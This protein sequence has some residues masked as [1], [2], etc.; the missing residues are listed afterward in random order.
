MTDTTTLKARYSE[1]HSTLQGRR[2][3]VLEEAH[4]LS[5]F[6]EAVAIERGTPARVLKIGQDD[7]TVGSHVALP[8]SAQPVASSPSTER[9]NRNPNH[10]PLKESHMPS[11]SIVTPSILA[12]RAPNAPTQLSPAGV[13]IDPKAIEVAIKAGPQGRAAQRK[14]GTPNKVTRKA[15][16]G[17]EALELRIRSKGYLEAIANGRETPAPG[18][19]SGRSDFAAWMAKNFWKDDRSTERN[20]LARANA[21]A[22]LAAAKAAA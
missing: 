9:L 20:A 15:A 1:T 19:K 21:K 8:A 14:P 2:L 22:A 10:N 11:K 17:K 5:D 16:P 6:V 13:T 18:T 4:I 3:T 12:R 7:L